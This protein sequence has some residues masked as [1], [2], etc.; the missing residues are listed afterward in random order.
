MTFFP[1][2]LYQIFGKNTQ[3][4]PIFATNQ[5]KE[6]IKYLTLLNVQVYNT[7][8]TPKDYDGDSSYTRFSKRADDGGISADDV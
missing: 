5:I 6:T 8:V 1:N 7:R 2:V 3:I 4:Y